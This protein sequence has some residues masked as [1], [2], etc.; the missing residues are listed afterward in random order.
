MRNLLSSFTVAFLSLTIFCCENANNP[1]PS[2]ESATSTMA[3]FSAA[4]ASNTTAMQVGPKI[5]D[6]PPVTTK[7]EWQLAKSVTMPYNK[8][9]NLTSPFAIVNEDAGDIS[10]G[11]DGGCY[12]AI[13][14]WKVTNAILKIVDVKTV[15]PADLNALIFKKGQVAWAPVSIYWTNYMPEGTVI[16]Y[17]MSNGQYKLVV[18]KTRTPLVL[19]IYQEHYYQVY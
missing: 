5:T 2:P 15:L 7:F 8:G 14:S 4:S 18:V 1:Q 13:K 10:W 17:K 3:G 6:R 9:L 12:S 16:A 11:S 19:D